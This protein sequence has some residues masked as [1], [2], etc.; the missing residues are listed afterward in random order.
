M[1][2]LYLVTC[3]CK[4]AFQQEDFDVYCVANSS[5]DAEDSALSLMRAWGYRYTGW[6]SNIKLIASDVEHK[7]PNPLVVTSGVVA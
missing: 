7:A 6:V 1:N 5:T 2:N 4:R 3:S